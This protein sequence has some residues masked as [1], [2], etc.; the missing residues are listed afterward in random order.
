MYVLELMAMLE[1]VAL[2]SVA[3]PPLS[4]NAKSPASSAP[5]PP[6]VL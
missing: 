3:V 6:E 4:A 1:G 2:E 5:L